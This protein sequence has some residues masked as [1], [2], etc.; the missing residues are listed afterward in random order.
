[1]HQKNAIEYLS[2]F[3][4]IFWDFDGV[5]KDSVDVKTAAFEKLFLSYDQKF[6]TAIKQ[7][8]EANSGMSRFEKIPIYL[9]WV[10]EEVTNESVRRYSDLFS[11]SVLQAVIDSR[12][13]PGVREWITR[14]YE[15]K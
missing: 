9:A 10:G 2:R 7:H 8:H 5:I 6:V 14:N 4:V 1:M 3:D 13:V 11:K 12:W 15:N